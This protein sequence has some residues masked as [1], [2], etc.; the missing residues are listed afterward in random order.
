LHPVA[1]QQRGGDRADVA[2]ALDRD[3][4]ARDRHAQVFERLA[5]DV[6]A[7]AAGRLAAA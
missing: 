7:P 5:G 1:R 4:G 6:H 2:E 3:G